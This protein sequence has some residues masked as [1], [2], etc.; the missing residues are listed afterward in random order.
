MYN[1][2]T[3]E[4]SFERTFSAHFT[5]AKNVWNNY[6]L[7]DRNGPAFQLHSSWLTTHSLLSTF[8]FSLLPTFLRDWPSLLVR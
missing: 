8:T 5:L 2:F 1:I 7:E 6:S 3:K 4:L